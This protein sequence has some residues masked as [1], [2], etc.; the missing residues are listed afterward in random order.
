MTKKKRIPADKKRCQVIKYNAFSL[1][2]DLTT[3]C[4]NEPSWIVEETIPGKDGLKGSQSVC[5]ECKQDWQHKVPKTWRWC[6]IHT[7]EQELDKEIHSSH[8][9]TNWK[10]TVVQ[11]ANTP[12]HGK[13]RSCKKCGG[14]QALTTAGSGTHS[15]LYSKC[16]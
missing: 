15:E 9:M 16:S 12:R 14:E 11:I 5:S 13:I 4:T 1:G 8:K 10:S 7:R 2:G 6:K 3:R